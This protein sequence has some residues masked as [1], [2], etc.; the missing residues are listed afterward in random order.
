MCLASSSLFQACLKNREKDEDEKTL[1]K[2]S[3]KKKEKQQVVRL[4]KE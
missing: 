2:K 1:E 3:E 4:Q